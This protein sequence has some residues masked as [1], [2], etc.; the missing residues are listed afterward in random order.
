MKKDL[1]TMME[2]ITQYDR[3]C[4]VCKFAAGCSGFIPGPNGPI[5]P[6]CAEGEPENWIDEQS[7]Q[8]IYEEIAEEENESI[9]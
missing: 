1:D 6:P 9:C 3:Q 4:D 5:Y 7:L 8:T 2:K